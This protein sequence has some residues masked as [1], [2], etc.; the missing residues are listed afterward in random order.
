M[1]FVRMKDS[2]GACC[3][4]GELCSFSVFDEKWALE[5]LRQYPGRAPVSALI[6]HEPHQNELLEIGYVQSGDRYYGHG[7]TVEEAWNNCLKG[8]DNSV[9]KYA[10][11]GNQLR[12]FWFV[13]YADEEDDEPVSPY[14]NQE[15][16]AIVQQLPNVV[17]L[18]V[19][20][21]ANSNNF[22]DGYMAIFTKE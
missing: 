13:S 20:R 22:V 17:K 10:Y 19:H 11:E 8:V 3:A 7:A 2:Y 6:V 15:L 4:T 14:A 9:Q 12:Y 1:I 16:R 5:H 18:G 21:N